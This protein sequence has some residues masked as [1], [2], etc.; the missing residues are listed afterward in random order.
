MTF[1]YRWHDVRILLQMLLFWRFCPR[2]WAT[3][4]LNNELGFGEGMQFWKCRVQARKKSIQDNTWSW[5]LFD[6]WAT[7][8]VEITE[9]FPT[10]LGHGYTIFMSIIVRILHT[11]WLLKS[12]ITDIPAIVIQRFPLDKVFWFALLSVFY[13]LCIIYNYM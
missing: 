13:K 2:P 12:N 4:S 9:H 6:W 7:V 11:V 3:C 8:L 5:F 1:T 10:P